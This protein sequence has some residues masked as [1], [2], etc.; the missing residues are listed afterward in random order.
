MSSCSRSSA[1][2]LLRR[3][4]LDLE[5]DDVA[6]PPPA[7]L[8]LDQ[9]EVRAAAFV[10]ELELGVARQADDRRFEDRLAGKELRQVR[11]DDVLEQHE[12]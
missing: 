7:H 5:P 6:A 10:V 3:R 1:T 11:A 8:A 2:Q 9:L 12:A 4:R